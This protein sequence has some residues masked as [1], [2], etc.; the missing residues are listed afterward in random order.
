MDFD[1][2]STSVW[3]MRCHSHRVVCCIYLPKEYI[4]HR[5]WSGHSWWHRGMAGFYVF[6]R[7]TEKNVL[8]LFSVVDFPT[9]KTE[10]VQKF[11]V[12]YLGMLPV[13]KPV[14]M[15]N[16][17]VFLLCK[18]LRALRRCLP[19]PKGPVCCFT[20]FPRIFSLLP[21]LDSGPC[22]VTNQST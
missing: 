15:S 20:P 14:G 12:Q 9:P 8:L 1:W 7:T 6:V 19:S 18:C 11:H 16:I 17:Y 10:L 5:W 21:F 22:T 4:M 13:D 2:Q 3:C